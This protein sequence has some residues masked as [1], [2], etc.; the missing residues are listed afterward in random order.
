MIK[1]IEKTLSVKVS[2]ELEISFYPIFITS[3][4][5]YRAEASFEKVFHRTIFDATVDGNSVVCA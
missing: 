2:S 5:Y 1:T 4:R 3:S